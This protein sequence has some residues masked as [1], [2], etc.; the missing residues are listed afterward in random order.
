MTLRRLVVLHPYSVGCLLL[1]LEQL[2]SQLD[3][4]SISLVMFYGLFH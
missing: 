1:Y 4:D 2:N 3:L